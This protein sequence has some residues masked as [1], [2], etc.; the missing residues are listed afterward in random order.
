MVSGHQTEAAEIKY[1]NGDG[2]TGQVLNRLRHGFGK[3]IIA[4][5]GKTVTFHWD[6]DT[7]DDTKDITMAFKAWYLEGTLNGSSLMSGKIIITDK[8][9]FVGEMKDF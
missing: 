9:S 3:I 6:Q 2:Y 7:L 4:A 5:T 8:S 1:K